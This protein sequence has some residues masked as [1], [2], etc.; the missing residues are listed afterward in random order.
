[1]NLYLFLFQG[2]T[3]DLMLFFKQL[4]DEASFHNLFSQ[5]NHE[6]KQI[7]QPLVVRFFCM[8]KERRKLVFVRD[9]GVQKKASAPA[10]CQFAST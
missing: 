10:E 5:P 3:S 8:P 7:A 6:V 9:R 1:M 4:T 2:F